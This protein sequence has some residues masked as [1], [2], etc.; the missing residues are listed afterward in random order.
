KELHQISQRVAG[1]RRFG[2]AALDLAFVAAGR[3]DG[4]WERDLK[5]WDLA[6][7]LLLVSEAGGKVT[8]LDGGEDVLGTGAVLASN[9]ELHP[10]VLEKLKLAA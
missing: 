5:P 9:L 4:F 6:A 10:L 3:F 1:V 2:A 8:D 7:G